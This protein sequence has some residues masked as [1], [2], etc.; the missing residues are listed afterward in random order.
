MFTSETLVRKI[1]RPNLF[2]VL[3]AR[4]WVKMETYQPENFGKRKTRYRY[5]RSEKNDFWFR[6]DRFSWLD[7]PDISPERHDVAVF[8]GIYFPV[9]AGCVH[10]A[11]KVAI[12]VYD[13]NRFSG[14][15]TSLVTIRIFLWEEWKKKF[16]QKPKI[17]RLPSLAK[18]E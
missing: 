3:L 9:S 14:R 5:P 11:V 17:G 1:V 16:K 15:Q 13:H 10:E 2:K 18:P 4:E 7:V 8:E 6:P 12:V